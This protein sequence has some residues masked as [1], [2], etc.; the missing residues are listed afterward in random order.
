MSTLRGNFSV[1]SPSKGLRT[2]FAMAAAV[3]LMALTLPGCSSGGG[4]GGDGGGS[5]A[6]GSARSGASNGQIRAANLTPGLVDEAR[7]LLGKLQSGQRTYASLDDRER[8]LLLAVSAYVKE[9][10]DKRR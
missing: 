4:S 6:R 3:G 7:V 8:Q 10:K 9:T 1:A 2:A 5:G